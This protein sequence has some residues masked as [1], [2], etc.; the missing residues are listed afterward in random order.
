MAKRPG[1]RGV[2]LGIQ[3]E[4]RTLRDYMYLKETNLP[5]DGIFLT[6]A[7]TTGVAIRRGM[8]VFFRG[9]IYWSG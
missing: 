6:C 3:L 8:E 4:L 2:V 5:K 1:G 7:I 9:G